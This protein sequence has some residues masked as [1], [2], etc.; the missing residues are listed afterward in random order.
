MAGHPRESSVGQLG[1]VEAALNHG[2]VGVGNGGTT[3]VSVDYGMTMGVGSIGT[4]TAATVG[5]L[6]DASV[7]H[8]EILRDG[9]AGTASEAESISAGKIGGARGHVDAAMKSRDGFIRTGRAID[10]IEVG[11]DRGNEVDG[12]VGRGVGAMT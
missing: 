11:R 7:R 6:S 1:G 10:R 3:T 12:E 2:A 9:G 4:K 5:G 8:L